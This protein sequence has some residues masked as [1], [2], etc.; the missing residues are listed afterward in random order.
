MH[1][2]YVSPQSHISQAKR[3]NRTI[4]ERIWS[5]FHRLPF[6]TLPKVVLIYL[7]TE[8]ANRL[9]NF[10]AKLGLSKYYSHRMILHKQTLVFKTR[11]IHHISDYILTH[12]DS[13]IKSNLRLRV[14]DYL[15][16]QPT[17]NSKITHDFYHISTNRVISGSRYTPLLII[18]N[19]F[20][21]IVAQAKKDNISEELKYN[22]KKNSTV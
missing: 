12:N 22:I 11:A 7:V 2:Q 1:I 17:P 21:F 13:I 9:N 19:I 15:Y 10:P 14:L 3:N 20:Q 18:T 6:T 8:C 16:L 5:A 4:N